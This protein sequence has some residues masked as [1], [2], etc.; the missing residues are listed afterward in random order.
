MKD[1]E[2]NNAAVRE[3]R[4]MLKALCLCRDCKQQDAYTLAGRTYCAECA[5]KLAA[6]KRECREDAEFRV[7]ANARC[8]RWRESRTD[9]GLC[10]R[11][12]RRK[13]QAGRVLCRYCVAKTSRTRRDADIANGMNWP[14][15]AN[16]YC[17]QCNK[18]LAMEGKRLCPEC[19]ERKVKLL[20][21]M[22]T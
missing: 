5:A 22:R 20:E 12:G 7:M 16:G 1:R 4:A 10:K 9:A 17:W 15:G 21:R 18:R 2:A 19:Y 14:R 6:V 3:N 8:R 11:C 13:P